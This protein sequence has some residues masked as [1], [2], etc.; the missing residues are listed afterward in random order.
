MAV[1]NFIPRVWSARLLQNL[2]NELVYARLLNTDYEG[3]ITDYGDTVHI[4]Q[5]GKVATKKYTRNQ[6][7]DAPEDL[8]TTDTTLL[9]DQGQYFNISIDDVDAAQARTGLMDQ[10]MAEASYS[11][12]SDADKYIASVLEKG[13]AVKGL[14]STGTPLTINTGELAYKLLVDMKVLL[15]KANVP[16]TGRWVVMPP[17][18]EG[19]MLLDPRFAYNTQDS[20]RRLETGEVGRAAGFSIYIS[21]NVPNTSETKYKIIGSYNGAGTFAQQILKTE[22]YRPEKR[23]SDA[24]KGLHVY[25]AKA[26]RPGAIAVATVNFTASDAA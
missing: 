15:D 1:T 5:I 9:I 2:N 16:K 14:G 18:F 6:D 7:I 17:E 21:N 20:N 26:T 4:G 3:E 13:T 25:G 11:L 10:A 8:S 12:A 24:V 19:L 23:F 22:A